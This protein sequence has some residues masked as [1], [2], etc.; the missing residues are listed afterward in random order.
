MNNSNH[1]K[2]L[3]F[4]SSE[5]QK[6]RIDIHRAVDLRIDLFLQGCRVVEIPP[7]KNKITWLKSIE[8]L[9]LFYNLLIKYEYINCTWE[10]FRI[11]FMG[12]EVSLDKIIFLKPINQLPYIIDCLQRIGYIT[13]CDHPHIRLAQHFDRPNKP[14]LNTVLRSS[15][16]K[17]VGEKTKIFI[18]ENI[19]DK[20]I[21]HNG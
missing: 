5:A 7:A 19:I 15:L 16:N 20:L 12:N 14:I 1:N 8:A 9:L 3:I 10:F 17:S 13:V 2:T 6:L 11:H 21:N 18:D 4:E